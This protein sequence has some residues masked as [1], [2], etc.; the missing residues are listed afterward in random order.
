MVKR[1]KLFSKSD[2]RITHDINDFI[3]DKDIIS[4]EEI[5]GFM[6][7]Y[8]HEHSK[9]AVNEETDNRDLLEG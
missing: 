2:V 5:D 8:W 7:V 9:P 1:S 6:I 3:K 4:I